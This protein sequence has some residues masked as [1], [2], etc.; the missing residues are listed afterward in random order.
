MP[1]PKEATLRHAA[2]EKHN[3]V[4]ELIRKHGGQE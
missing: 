1:R 3:D 4:A 2:R